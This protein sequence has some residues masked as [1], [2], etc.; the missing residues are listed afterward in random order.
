MGNEEK[1]RCK[2]RRGKT[3]RERRRRKVR[4][5]NDHRQ[6][7]VEKKQGARS[8]EG[9]NGATK[10]KAKK[11]SCNTRGRR[12]SQAV[13]QLMESMRETIRL[14]KIKVSRHLECR[15]GAAHLDIT[16]YGL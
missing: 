3:R 11:V 13:T 1:Q 14:T 2:G 10:A 8:E 7:E 12:G 6:G 15:C 16:A 4:R 5:G 9:G